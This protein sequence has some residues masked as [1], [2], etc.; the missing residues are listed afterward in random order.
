GGLR[1]PG[2]D[3]Q[4]VIRRDR[5]GQP[6]RPGGRTATLPYPDGGGGDGAGDDREPGNVRH[7]GEQRGVGGRQ[8]GG[9][10]RQPGTGFSLQH[11]HRLRRQQ[12]AG[13][14][15]RSAGEQLAAAVVVVGYPGGEQRG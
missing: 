13:Q 10:L 12:C 4:F 8:R 11:H 9:G 2:E 6:G 7:L 1:Q 3:L 14:R 15:R 5:P